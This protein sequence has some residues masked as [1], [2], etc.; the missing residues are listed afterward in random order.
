MHDDAHSQPRLI[1]GYAMKNRYILM[2]KFI[3]AC[4][5]QGMENLFIHNR[6]IL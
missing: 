1:D 3:R 6:S 5:A 4:P 2:G